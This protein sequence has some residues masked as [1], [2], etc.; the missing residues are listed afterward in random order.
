M[1]LGN[2]LIS[3]FILASSF[4]RTINWRD[5][6]S[7]ILSSCLLFQGLSDYK[8]IALL[9]SSLF[10]SIDLHFC[11]VCVYVQYQT[12]LMSVIIIKAYNSTVLRSIGQNTV[13]G[14][15]LFYNIMLASATHTTNQPQVYIC[16]L[17]P[18]TPLYYK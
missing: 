2:I 10:Y 17:P 4:P 11:F 18:E 9:P 6:L 7:S 13:I 14:G 1:V 16:P 12:V 15:Q 5:N 8:G 3:F